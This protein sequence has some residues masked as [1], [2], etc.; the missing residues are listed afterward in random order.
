MELPHWLS[1]PETPRYVTNRPFRRRRNPA[2]LLEKA[3]R[4]LHRFFADTLTAESTAKK[5]GLWQALDPRI[6]LFTVVGLV[7]LITVEK[8]LVTLLASYGL[9][10]AFAAASRVPFLSF[11][12]RVWSIILLFAGV[13]VF[14]LAL[15]RVTPGEPL[16]VLVKNG[17]DLGFFR[18]PGPLTVT[19]AGLRHASTIILRAGTATSLV[20]L[21][22]FTTP[23]TSL[24]KALRAFYVPRLV[25]LI[26]EITFRYIFL[27]LKVAIEILE[28]RKLRMVGPFN[29]GEKRAFFSA[30][31]GTIVS[32]S[33]ALHEAVYEAMLARGYTGEPEVINSFR[34]RTL[35]AG[36]VAA[37]ALVIGV[38]FYLDRFLT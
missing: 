29:R 21:L 18:L 22:T 10:L 31:F 11:L 5:A 37:I 1:E 6:K 33:Y 23:W 36:W 8:H 4:G 35:D 9:V 28:A 15:N 3:L 12:G 34:L 30:V 27:L 32:K 13:V 16:L 38:L 20:L 2:G 25:V 19:D 26:V 17:I 7:G 24:L 14:P